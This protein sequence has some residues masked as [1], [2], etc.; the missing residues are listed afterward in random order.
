MKPS[1]DACRGHGPPSRAETLQSS[2]KAYALALIAPAQTEPHEKSLR[3]GRQQ[4]ENLVYHL[5]I[6]PHN[7]TVDGAHRL[8]KMAVTKEGFTRGRRRGEV[9]PCADTSS[10]HAAGC[11]VA[12]MT[13]GCLCS[14]LPPACAA[15]YCFLALYRL[16]A[17]GALLLLQRQVAGSSLCIGLQLCCLPV[18]LHPVDNC[19]AP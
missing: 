6:I 5:N 19:Y 16:R 17:Q 11:A 1:I 14:S 3:V 7:D 8:Y 10:V 12:L 18:L 13:A 15:C 9:R 2:S 4:L